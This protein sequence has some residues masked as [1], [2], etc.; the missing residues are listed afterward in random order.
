MSFDLDEHDGAPLPPPTPPRAA[1]AGRTL[2]H[3]LE[4][5]EYLLSTCLLDGANVVAKCLEAK[6]APYSFYDPKHGIIYDCIL[7]IYRRELPIEISVVAQ[8]LQTAKQL[9]TVGGYAF[10]AQV[11]SRIPTTAQAD[12]FINKVRE[13]A[14]LRDV[15]RSS[16][17]IVEA[18]YGFAGG[19]DQFIA[20]TRE[21]IGRVLDDATGAP[22]LLA[23]RRFDP[24]AKI[25][26][27]RVA[28]RLNNITICTAGNLT[29][30]VA[31][32]G[33]GKSATV[34]AMMAAV[35]KEPNVAADCLGFTAENP[36]G[37]PLLH[38]DTEQSAADYQ[39]LLHRSLRR[40]GRAAFPTWFHSFHLTGLSAKECYNLVAIAIATLSRK[41]GGKLF[42][43]MIDGVGDLVANPN[44]ENECFPL[45][46]EL[47]KWAIRHDCPIINVLHLNPGKD[48]TK[49]R[50]H[51][52]S[53]LER[54][55]ETVIKL[56][57]DAERVTVLFSDG[58]DGTKKRGV[59][60][61]KDEGPR[62]VWNDEAK[63]HTL[64]KDWAEQAKAKTAERRARLKEARPTTFDAQYSREE[65]VSFYPAST[66]RPSVRG[67]I[68]RKA[69]EKSKISDSTLDRLRRTFLKDGWIVDI[70]GGYR[71]TREGDD[72]ASRRPG[73][74]IPPPQQAEVEF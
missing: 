23:A 5:E 44:D 63:M 26:E 15:I 18:S 16:T 3:S 64:V 41:H 10:L 69:Q 9:D 8:E 57:M 17:A 59:P 61:R 32:P 30:I 51:L 42:G 72:W 33:V 40:S 4:A 14:L 38:F 31:H 55:A 39:R 2:P 52:G 45:I 62:F 7:S 11:S 54:K 60:L 19:I 48:V 13:Q 36:D 70:D 74:N 12:Y 71:R 50:G 66:E 24:K 34:D 27:A 37:L 20:E 1:A 6:I 58:T 43:V 73:A 68:Y 29:N 21:K 46:T 22:E 28:Y 65:Q 25:V 53:Q 47:H 49:S 67:P 56:E 35:M